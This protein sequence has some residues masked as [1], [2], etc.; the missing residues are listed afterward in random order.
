MGMEQA[1]AARGSAVRGILN[2]V[3]YE[4]WDP[5]HDKHLPIHFG[6]RQLAQKAELKRNFL[7]RQKHDAH[8]GRVPLFGIV[9]RLRSQKGFDLLTDTLPALL[10]NQDVRVAVVGS[11]DAKY[12]DFFVDSPNA[13]ADARGSSADTTNR[14]RT[15]SRA[16]ATFSS[17]RRSTS[18]AASTRCIRCVTAPSPSC[19][20]R[21]DWPIQWCT[22][23]RPRARAPASCS[24]TSTPAP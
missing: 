1:L 5:R 18:P 10:Q 19:A 9:S 20:A 21:A 24:T 7:L 23:I 12:E 16:P 3:D 8:A 2:G 17:C 11:G 22:S 13:T 6:R 15:G 14:W 4:E